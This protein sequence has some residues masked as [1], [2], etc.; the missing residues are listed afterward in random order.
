MS[1]S[2]RSLVHE[3][4]QAL[5]DIMALCRAVGRRI[6]YEGPHSLEYVFVGTELYELNLASWRPS[7]DRTS[8][9]RP[10]TRARNNSDREVTPRVVKWRNTKALICHCLARNY[11]HSILGHNHNAGLLPPSLSIVLPCAL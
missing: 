11:R 8:K 2:M 5:N 10:K 4:T 9:R 6:Y 3:T 7:R 1:L